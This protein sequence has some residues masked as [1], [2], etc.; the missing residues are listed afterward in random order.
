MANIDLR[1]PSKAETDSLY[2]LYDAGNYSGAEEFCLQLLNGYPESGFV[3]NMLG[4][5]LNCQSRESEAIKAYKQAIR[6]EPGY[7]DSYNNL[8]LIIKKR[9]NQEEA[10]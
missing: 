3:L 4:V 1:N 2:N 8:G 5:V 10:L 6:V 9:G 7:A